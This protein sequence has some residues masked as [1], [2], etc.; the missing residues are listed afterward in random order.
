MILDNFTSR[1][2]V[3]AI[4]EKLQA[5][6]GLPLTL[7]GQELFLTCRIGVALYPQDAVE[8]EGLI[9]QAVQAVKQ[10]KS[11]GHAVQFTSP[12]VV[13]S[14]ASESASVASSQTK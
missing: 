12:I 11:G 5:T 9:T 13:S 14:A 4:V 6:V 8:H 10:A 3:M 2:E 7:E 1:E